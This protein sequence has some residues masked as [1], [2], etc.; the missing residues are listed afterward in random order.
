MLINE[1]SIPF[2]NFKTYVRI[3]G[4]KTKK[5]P[6]LLLHG[7]PGSSHNYFEVLDS[8]AEKSNRQIIM[9]DQLGCGKSS[10]PDDQPDL[11]NQNTWVKELINLREQLELEQI[12]LLGQSWGGML[13]IIYLCDYQPSGI[14]S[15]ILSSTLSSAS[16]WSKE[17]HNLIKKLPQDEQD[18]IKKAENSNDFSN[19]A[20]LKA[21]KHFMT[22]HV[23]DIN[24][25]LPE[26]VTRQK[27]GGSVAYQTAWGPNEYTPTGN[28]RNYEYTDKLSKIQKPVLI[29]SGSND[30]CT[31][32]VAQTMKKQLRQSTWKLFEGCGHMPFVQQ[33]HKYIDL[34]NNWL[35]KHDKE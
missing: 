32:L 15:V 20:Y 5:A 14:K 1:F 7:G 16:L 31:P 10:I 13:A 26:C 11:Y 34:L 4:K 2:L 27:I 33:Q 9:Y 30:L 25:T 12:H 22:E 18:A 21:N 29:T 28:L 8:L 19:S 3:V 17:L 24:Q 6:L 23:I 35:N